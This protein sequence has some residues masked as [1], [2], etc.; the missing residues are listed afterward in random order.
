MY[1]TRLNDTPQFWKWFLKDNPDC[2]GV[3]VALEFH[4]F[5]SKSSVARYKIFMLEFRV[6][7]FWVQ[8]KEID[9]VSKQNRS[10]RRN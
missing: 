8:R 1:P 5:Y 3:S 9:I 4:N 7:M 6:Y 10:Q 2:C